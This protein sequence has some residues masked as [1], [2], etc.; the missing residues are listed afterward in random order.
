MTEEQFITIKEL[1]MYNYSNVLE[2]IQQGIITKI[3]RR[4]KYENGIYRLRKEISTKHH[5]LLNEHVEITNSKKVLW[6]SLTNEE[7]KELLGNPDKSISSS[8]LNDL[9]GYWSKSFMA[10]GNTSYVWIMDFRY[11][12]KPVQQRLEV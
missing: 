6:L 4:T 8:Y 11:I 3:A 1:P 5:K 7:A 2:K 12:K 9:R 10:Y